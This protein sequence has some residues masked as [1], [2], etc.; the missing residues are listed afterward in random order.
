[1]PV[2]R[3]R[4]VN[5]SIAV[6]RLQ[7]FVTLFAPMHFDTKLHL[8]LVCMQNNQKDRFG[9]EPLIFFPADIFVGMSVL[10]GCGCHPTPLKHVFCLFVFLSARL[11]ICTSKIVGMI[12]VC[13][14]FTCYSPL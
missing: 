1:M 5:G 12:I 2:E 4:S 10:L 14:L 6:Q 8:I 3:R 13:V 7:A 9:T 11:V